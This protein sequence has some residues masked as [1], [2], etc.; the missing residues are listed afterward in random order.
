MQFAKKDYKI[1]GTKPSADWATIGVVDKC[2]LR[3]DFC[4]VRIT[5]L[6]GDYIYVYIT[7]NAYKKFENAIGMGSVMV[8]K[9]PLVLTANKPKGDAALQVKL[10]Q[11]MWVIGQS[12]DLKACEGYSKQG[13]VCEEWIDIRAGEYCDA[14]LTKVCNYSKNGRMELASGNTGIDIRWAIAVKQADGRIGYQ[15]KRQPDSYSAATQKTTKVDSYYIKGKGVINV[16]GELF[17]KAL[18]EKT[19]ISDNSAQLKE[20][21]K[22]RRDNG[23]EM[24]RKLKGIAEEKPS[25]LWIL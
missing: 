9:R 21:L 13:K 19:N 8:F 3:E 5:N 15:T 17:K 23:S 14:H 4:V 18:Q 7:D 10:V 20:F 2:V 16:K 12:S 22:E 25:K 6:K 24:I 11:Q 1:I